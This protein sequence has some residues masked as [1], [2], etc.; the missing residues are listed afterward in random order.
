MRQMGKWNPYLFPVSS[1]E[2]DRDE[3]QRRE[4]PIYFEA[5]PEPG[6]M[7]AGFAGCSVFRQCFAAFRD[8]ILHCWLRQRRPRTASPSQAYFFFFFPSLSFPSKGRGGNAAQRTSVPICSFLPP[9]G[10][11]LSSSE[12]ALP[13][14]QE[15][16]SQISVCGVSLWGGGGVYSSLRLCS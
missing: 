2:I 11:S 12:K 10:S 1:D 3:E 5:S 7:S 8:L 13:R 9:P 6:E 14:S 4:N 15:S 16:H